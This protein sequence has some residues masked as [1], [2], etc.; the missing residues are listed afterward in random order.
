[1]SYTVYKHTGPTGKVYIGITCQKPENRWG[2]D[3]KGYKHSPHFMAAIKMY[4]WEAFTHEIIADGLTKE[5]A[6]CMEVKL[7]AQYDSTNREKGYNCSTGG[8]RSSLGVIRSPEVCRKIGDIHRGKTVSAETRR[9]LSEANKGKHL[10]AEHRKK[11]SVAGRGRK[12]SEETR[13]KISRAHMGIR[14]NA[15]TRR[16]MSEMRRGENSPNYGKPSPFRV[17]VKCVDTGEVFVSALAAAR[18][19]GIAQGTISAVCRGKGKS[20]GGFR[21]AYV[22]E[23]GT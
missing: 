4:G 20:A 9:K 16:K 22:L 14:P 3:G 19:T 17:P 1:M 21:W 6:E 12:H 18:K 23:D 13:Q 10:S 15:E 2:R 8:E 7:I 11:L 5:E